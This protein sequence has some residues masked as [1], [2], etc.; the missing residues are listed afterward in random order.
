MRSADYCITVTHVDGE[1]WI[2]SSRF[3]KLV[4]WKRETWVMQG[5][6][7][8]WGRAPSLQKVVFTKSGLDHEDKWSGD[9]V[10]LVQSH[11]RVTVAQMLAVMGSCHTTQ[12]IAACCIWSSWTTDRS[13][14]SE[15]PSTPL[16]VFTIRSDLQKW[17]TEQWRKVDSQMFPLISQ[18]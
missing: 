4:C 10:Q 16:T 1:E 15:W 18:E 13:E 5:S 17:T 12:R 9:L 6:E 3:L 8:L 7:N 11:K 2:A 14:F